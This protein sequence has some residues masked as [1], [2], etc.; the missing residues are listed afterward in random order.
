VAFRF[1]LAGTA[2]IGEPDFA[3]SPGPGFWESR[4]IPTSTARSVRSSWQS[5]RRSA[6]ARLSGN[7]RTRRGLRLGWTQC[8]VRHAQRSWCFSPYGKHVSDPV[9]AAMMNASVYNDTLTTLRMMPARARSI[10]RN[11]PAEA[12][13]SLRATTPR[14]IP[15]TEP[16]MYSQKL[17][18]PATSDIVASPLTGG[19]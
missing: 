9:Q 8:A 12:L 10:P 19:C 3:A 4:S 18:I 16:T 7:P 2:V 17:R 14:T 5:I 6:K 11:C 13:I 15:A 1:G